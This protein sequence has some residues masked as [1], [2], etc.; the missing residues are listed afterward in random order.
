MRLKGNLSQ[1]KNSRDNQNVDVELYIDKIEYITNKKD[2][3][4]TQPFE[5]VDELDTPLVLTGD[6]LARVQDKHLEEGEFAYQVYDKV[7]GEYVLN[8]DKYLELTVAYD[9]D[10]D[11]TILTA[12]YYTVTVSNE[13][14]K[15]IKAERSKEKKQKKGKGR[16]GRS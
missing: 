9:F 1:I 14:F 4:Y 16:K 8:P 5:F 12:A 6:C 13:E 10:A 3:R 15:D 11:L 7:E 2:G